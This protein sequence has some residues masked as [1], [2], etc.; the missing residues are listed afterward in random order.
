MAFWGRQIFALSY[1]TSRII[2]MNSTAQVDIGPS[3]RPVTGSIFVAS[4]AAMLLFLMMA[5]P[6]VYSVLYIKAVLFGILLLISIS[7][8]ILTHSLSI[9]PGILLWTIAL[10]AI[11]VGYSVEGAGQNVEYAFREG[12]VYFLWPM[13]YVLL[14]VLITTAGD[15]IFICRVA[16]L[17]SI[18]IS[19]YGVLYALQSFSVIP[20]LEIINFL[21]LGDIQGVGIHGN[22]V[23]VLIS[24]LNSLPFLFPFAVSLIYVSYRFSIW[25]IGRVWLWLSLVVQLVLILLSGRRALWLLVVATP[26]V[27]YLVA[28]FARYSKLINRKYLG[29]AF[30][31]III[32][33]AV[34]L[35]LSMFKFG[36]HFGN[37]FDIFFNAFKFSGS[38]DESNLIRS[39]QF[40]ALIAGWK[41]APIIGHGFGTYVSS[42]IRSLTNPW[43]YELYYIALLYHTGIVGVMIYGIAIIWLI[44]RAVS[45]MRTDPEAGWF[46]L[47]VLMGLIGM[48]IATATN[49]YL[50]RFD[51]IWAIFFLAATINCMQW[52]RN[53]ALA[54]IQNA[55]TNDLVHMK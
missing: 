6:M 11:A 19:L 18:Y 31:L 14:L 16:I 54:T 17:A 43:S 10:C 52:R 9:K 15:L 51:G 46:V 7:K 4:L 20:Q 49:P 35:G 30:G 23:Q 39:E 26:V 22:Y 8:I 27:L 53:K 2:Y 50:D 29:H 33:I 47:P 45:I 42:D 28:I 12:Q 40:N 25:R 55:A 48:L 13:I 3:Y 38:N 24:G 44:K 34:G 32:L 5:Y 36:F 1:S 21:A 37:V 41:T